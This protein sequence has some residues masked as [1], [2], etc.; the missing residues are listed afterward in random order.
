M[1]TRLGFVSNSS[2]ASFIVRIFGTNILKELN[3]EFTYSLFDKKEVIAKLKESISYYEEHLQ[4]NK[5]DKDK[6]RVFLVE[7]YERDLASFKKT[8]SIIQKSSK[9]NL[10]KNIL[11]HYYKISV[12]EKSF[13]T[14]LTEFTAMYNS[15]SDI[16]PELKDIITF[17]TVKDPFSV[18][19]QVEDY[20]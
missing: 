5:E 4:T 1:K 19:V 20:N 14:E 18:E 9:K 12:N 10:V 16:S 7:L 11:K 6:W 13:Y 2:S 8:L 3:S 17:Y 15:V